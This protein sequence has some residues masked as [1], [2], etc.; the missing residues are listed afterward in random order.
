MN[1]LDKVNAIQHIRPGADFVLREQELEWLDT[2]Q[3]E[4]TE[5]EIQTAWID[6]QAKIE[7]AKAEAE[8]KK[9]ALLDRLGITAEEARLLL[10]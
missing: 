7:A 8:A 10:S 4:P 9:Q 5:S 2:E 3:I 6:Y 1:H